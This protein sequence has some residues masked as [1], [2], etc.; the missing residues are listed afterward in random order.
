MCSTTNTCTV[1]H[2]QALLNLCGKV[3]SVTC[4]LYRNEINVNT[5]CTH[6]CSCICSPVVHAYAWVCNPAFP[7]NTTLSVYVCVDVYRCAGLRQSVLSA[8]LPQALQDLSSGLCTVSTCTV[9]FWVASGC[10]SHIRQYG[11]RSLTPIMQKRWELVAKPD[12]SLGCCFSSAS[13]VAQGSVCG[14]VCKGMRI[15]K[16]HKA[17]WF[18]LDDWDRGCNTNC[19]IWNCFFF[20]KWLLDRLIISLGTK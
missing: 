7:L 1:N 18:P 17:P 3:G 12:I 4:L 15:L 9:H 14:Y 8:L 11:D 5:T 16:A 13:S 10:C 19:W 2:D 20:K 6:L